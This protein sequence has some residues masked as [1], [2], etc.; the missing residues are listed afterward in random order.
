MASLR[1][2][3]VSFFK[4][5][6]INFQVDSPLARPSGIFLDQEQRKLFVSNYADQSMVCYKI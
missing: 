6:N 1:Y 4:V 2:K 3:S 5:N